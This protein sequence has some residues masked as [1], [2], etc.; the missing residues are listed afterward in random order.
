MPQN[1]DKKPWY[2]QPL[3]WLVIFFPAT[4]VV[5]G[6]T[7]LIISINIDDGTVV[8]DYYKRGKEINL[9]LTRDR[10]AAEM[11]IRGVSVYSAD[12]RRFSVTLASTEGINLDDME[13]QLNLLHATRGGM[14]VSM[15][16]SLADETGLYQAVLEKELALGP[17]HVQIGNNDWRIHGRIHIPDDYTSPL[18]AR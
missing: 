16:M 12:N 9:V 13:I 15:P 3:V 7:L 4:A 11:G 18:S 1:T 2:T 8:D 14:D 17:W 10:K 6:I 5:G